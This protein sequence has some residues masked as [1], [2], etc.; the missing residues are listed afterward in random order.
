[1]SLPP[2]KYKASDYS[3]QYY[4][5]P[6]IVG[7]P[8]GAGQITGYVLP[9]TPPTDIQAL[10]GP[11]IP[12]NVYSGSD[13]SYYPNHLPGLSSH[14]DYRVKNTQP[15]MLASPVA[16]AKQSHMVLFAVLALAGIAALLLYKYRGKLKSIL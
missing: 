10:Q 11:Y 5:V 7:G 15:I 2:A 9:N 3:I 12:G 8:A 16:V 1:M 13:P 6:S 4:P 14:F